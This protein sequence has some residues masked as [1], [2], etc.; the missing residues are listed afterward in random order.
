M[1]NPSDARTLV[2]HG[3]RLRGF[4]ESPAIASAVGLPPDE[5]GAELPALE[6]EGL[7]VH[8]DGRLSGWTLT[9]A[10]RVEQQRRLTA[11]LDRAG[12]RADVDAAYRGFLSLNNE[13]LEVCTAWQLR[14][15]EPNDHTDERYDASVVDRLRDLHRRVEPVLDRLERCFDRYRGYRPRLET[16][17]GKL[18]AGDREWFTKP[19][20]DS[21]HTVWFQLHEDLLNTLGLERSKEA[22]G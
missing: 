9:P 5:V 10:G 16:A 11:E 6:A 3:V 21:Y 8:R 12:C 13:L 22:A 19:L 20:I 1:P 4:G 17:L 2:L 15:D 14:G 7:A 18:D